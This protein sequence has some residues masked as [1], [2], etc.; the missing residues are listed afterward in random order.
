M[1]D[2]EVEG[3]PP[4]VW[5]EIEADLDAECKAFGDALV[6]E[7]KAAQC[8]KNPTWAELITGVTPK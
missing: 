5:E 6:K 2:E 4:E 1:D 7:M 8:D 3:A